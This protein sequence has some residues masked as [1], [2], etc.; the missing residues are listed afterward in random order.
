M[1]F[2][3]YGVQT[4]GPVEVISDPTPMNKKDKGQLFFQLNTNE[5][6]REKTGF[7]HMQKQRRRSAVQYLHS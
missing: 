7:L 4:V 6:H 5:L 1:Q 2:L 3:K